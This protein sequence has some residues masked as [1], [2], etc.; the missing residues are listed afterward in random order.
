MDGRIENPEHGEP[1]LADGA[2]PIPMIVARIGGGAATVEEFA[3][4]HGVDMGEVEVAITWTLEHPGEIREAFER[5][6]ESLSDSDD[7]DWEEY[8]ERVEAALERVLDGSY[9]Y[10]GERWSEEPE[11]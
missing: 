7:L 4:E 6:A 1:R 10:V 8:L 5:R 9:A 3:D 11:S 2:I